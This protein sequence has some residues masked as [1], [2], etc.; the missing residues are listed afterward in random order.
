MARKRKSGDGTVRLRK[1]G[2]WEGRVV[3]GYD[4]NGYPQT[5]NVLAKTKNECLE[6]LRALK[7][8]CGGLKSEKLRPEMPFGDWLEYWYKN[9]SKPKL[10][11]TTQANYESRIHLHIMPEIGKIPLNK[12]TQND[13]QQ[14]YAR[15]KKTGRLRF[16]DQY[17]EG[18]S[19]R[20]V[21]MCHAVCRTALEKACLLYTSSPGAMLLQ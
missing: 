5:K 9:H 11:P 1:D 2:R 14:F 3:I 13:L 6:K 18:L 21:R 7:E 20:M 8:S 10:R 17:G 15:L 4:D 12:L 19:D 16:T